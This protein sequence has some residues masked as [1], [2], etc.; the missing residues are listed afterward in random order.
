MNLDQA[1]ATISAILGGLALTGALVGYFRYLRPRYRRSKAVLTAARDSLVGRE[2]V[3]DSI[4]GK[5]LAPALPGIGERMASVETVVERIATVIE[6]QQAQDRRLADHESRIKVLEDAVVE[7]VF[8]KA[9]SAA[10]WRAVE[11]VANHAAPSDDP[12]L[13]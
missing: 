2:A 5:E 11:A 3:V 1:Q 12:E 7:R 4:T 10:A 6:G 9:E 13:G 8:S